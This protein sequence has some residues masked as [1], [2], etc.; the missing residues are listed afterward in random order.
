MERT[1]EKKMKNEG[2][3]RKWGKSKISKFIF[4]QNGRGR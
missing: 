2:E 4:G 1:E 3:K